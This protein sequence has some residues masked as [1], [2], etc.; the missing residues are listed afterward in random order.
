MVVDQRQRS[1]R[2][3]G[4]AGGRGKIVGRAQGQQPERWQRPGRFIAMG[5]RRGRLAQGAVA[6][7]GD[8]AIDAALDRFGHVAIGVAGLPGHADVELHPAFAH[9]GHRVAYGVVA[10]G[11]AIE[12]QAPAWRGH[13]HP[14]RVGRHTLAAPGLAARESRLSCANHRSGRP[15]ALPQVPRT[16]L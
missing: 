1:G 4:N 15:K 7:A 12:D 5:E 2:F 9:R 3:G 11:L 14:D 6:A 13:A 8:H 10:G 16:R